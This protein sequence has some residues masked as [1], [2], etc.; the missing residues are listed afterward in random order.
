MILKDL[1]IFKNMVSFLKFRHWQLFVFTY[2]LPITFLVASFQTHLDRNIFPFMMLC[3]TT[4]LY[5]W[6]WSIATVLNRKLPAGV[7]LNVV[8]FKIIFA[9]PFIYL[10]TLDIW[11]GFLFSLA[12]LDNVGDWW[13]IF[14]IVVLHF[15]SIGCTIYGIR[16]AAKTLK[17]IELGRLAHFQ[18]YALEFF[19]L[20][21]TI[22]G[23]WVIQPKLNR[24]IGESKEV[25]PTAQLSN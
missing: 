3:F 4:F 1:P 6:I 14:L 23:Y 22:I 5:G 12:P 2:G 21:I 9:V 17:S 8:R 11:M 18:D 24:L 25:V 16:F 19:L 20:W 15:I 10:L 13:L 7:R